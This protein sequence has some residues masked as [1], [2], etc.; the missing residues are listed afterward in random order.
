MTTTSNGEAKLKTH[1]NDNDTDYWRRQ[2]EEAGHR[3]NGGNM[4]EWLSL[5]LFVEVKSWC[6]GWVML[7]SRV[8]GMGQGMD[9]WR[10]M[11][12]HRV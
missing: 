1:T 5:L 9:T 8:K 10:D 4:A 11:T 7:H 2:I 12:G 3:E 6:S